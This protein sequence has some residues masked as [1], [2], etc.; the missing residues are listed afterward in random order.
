[1]SALRIPENVHQ[2]V[3]THLDR[4]SG[5]HFAFLLARVAD[6]AGH[7][8][9]LV[10]DCHLVPDHLVVQQ[11]FHAEV[12]PDSVVAAVNQAVRTSSALVELHNHRQECP[13]F[14]PTDR[15]GINALLPY[16]FRS[17]PGRPYAA[18]V[19]GTEYIHGRFFLPDGSTDS[20]DSITIAGSRLRQLVSRGDDHREASSR[21]DRQVL[22][23]REP[24]QRELSRLTVAIVGLGG[25]GS[26]VALQLPYLGILSFV[27]VDHDVLEE[28]NLNRVV[29]ASSTD[30]GRLKVDLAEAAIKRVVPGARILARSERVPHPQVTDALKGADLIFGCVDNDGARLVLNE[31]SRAYGIPYF[32]LA[33]G[34]HV[35]P[36]RPTVA[37]GRLAAVLPGGPCLHCMGQI[38]PAEA[39]FFHQPKGVQEQ[40]LAQGYVAGIDMP[41]PSVVSL[42]G[43]VASLAISELGL[44]VTGERLIPPHLRL[45]LLG[46]S[47]ED[48]RQ[49]IIEEPYA[50]GHPIL[51]E[52]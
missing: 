43:T 8:T 30:V 6:A 41:D 38:D 51:I 7:P 32:D 33:T 45:D 15:D 35:V 22:W 17:L 20:I 39:R 24:A 40:E 46:H 28:T 34:I 50:S 18:T 26:H 11:D 16:L 23:F 2:R 19:W 37:G 10:H 49:R 31:I 44:Y 36:G 9:F 21:F 27:L 14:S 4:A 13:R 3:R 47:W 12:A 48:P 25:L 5:E 42:N 52:C 29:T 1:M